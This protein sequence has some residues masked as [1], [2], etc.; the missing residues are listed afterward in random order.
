MAERLTFTLTGRDELSRALNGA[1]DSADR[2]RLRL[3][4]ITA[5]ADGRLHDL[6]GR[7]VSV[8]DAQRRLAGQTD[9]TRHSFTSLSD[10]TGKFGE[11]LKANLIS[12]A[13]AAIPAAAGLAGAAATVA[14]QL[15]AAG[16]A[17][18]AYAL[19]LGP[20]ITAI[21]E[22]V[23]AQQTYEDAVTSSGAH[24]QQ[25]AQAQA[26][27][28]QQLAKL[29]PATQRAAV[30]VGLLRDNF[31]AWSD[32]L[33]GDVLGPFTK[34]LAIADTLLPKTTVLVKSASGQFDRLVTLLG[35]AIST[36]GFDRLTGKFTAFA[37]KTLT[38]AVDELTVFLAKADVGQVGTGLNK[39]LDYARANGPAV[40]DTLQ[41]VGDA[42]LHI[43]QAGSDV[44]VSMLG[45][46]N[47]LSN[48]V[49]AVPPQAIADLL[50]LAIAIKAV[51]L[52]AAGGTVLAAFG[53][54]IV[55][56]RTAAAG[57]PGVLAGVSAA[58]AG[59]SR[60]TKVALAG[61]GLGL[62]VIALGEISSHSKTTAPDV[63][64]LTISLGQLGRTGK[65]TGYLVSLTGK[66]FTDLSKTIG[67]VLDPSV[68]DSINNWGH[69]LS[70]TLFKASE[71]TEKFTAF[72]DSTDKALTSLVS[73]GH[74]DIAA[75]ALARFKDALPPDQF[76]KLS[77]SLEGYHN[78]LAG[79]AFEQ[80]LA[81]DTAGIFGD[82]AQQVQKALDQQKKAAD[83][84][85]QSIVALNE[86]HRQG[87]DAEADFEAAIDNG[88]AAAKKYGNV[89]AANGGKLDLTTAKGR[90]AYHALSDLA[91]K[92]NAA[93]VAGLE[94][95]V[96]WTKVNSTF[97]RGRQQ[98]I[99][100]AMQMGLNRDAAKRLADQILKT[101]NK[102]A[103]LKGDIKDLQSKLN[104][105]KSRLK[106][107]PDSRKAKVR[108]DISQLESQVREAKRQLAILN[109]STV[110]VRINGV[111]TGVNAAQYYS[112]GPHA[113]GG[114]IHRAA[115][116][117]LPGFPG[118]GLLH[119]P[120]TSMSDSIPVL[121]SNGEF[122]VN[123]MAT[124]KNLPLLEAINNGRLP[125]GRGAPRAGLAA[126][127]TSSSS[128][129][130]GP[131]IVNNYAL[132]VRKSVIDANDL[133]LIQRQEEARQ[134]VGRPR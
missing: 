114:L 122:V 94:A 28:Q 64:K 4:G 133:R 14:A 118:G 33:A 132:N 96:G 117:L 8:A 83:G 3:A 125:V 105:A 124:A 104:T 12:L 98:L 32:S 128:A 111:A 70:S 92:T 54:Q 127:A 9:G 77:D 30:A 101:P 78:A 91:A 129:S 16:A 63:D 87:L 58:V 13:P 134:R 107:V 1:A 100:N 49:S 131:Q 106:S 93:T 6:Q 46:I 41:N 52:A 35:G 120:G 69:S 2:L 115:G 42:L 76:K 10:A 119:G 95:N 38:H 18:G 19:A 66:N 15:G 68:T 85:R 37:D 26:A 50:Q 72:V 62:L 86:V 109:G 20:Q 89:W 36:P 123:A 59:L 75:A 40:F 25:A 48:I 108:A 11:A 99:K 102:T 24:S 39:F 55:A 80:K 84:L 53:R 22:A 60:T 113:L 57:T 130:G 31:K 71:S 45:L 21:G 88:T 7:F 74:A 61:T 116:G 112:Q 82:Q 47:A 65:E 81:A 97:E 27:Y 73:G 121:A 56:M 126:A 34:G 29:P 43:L 23:K 44:G 90:D 51:K 5:D 79:A 110:T 103:K 17:A 67:E